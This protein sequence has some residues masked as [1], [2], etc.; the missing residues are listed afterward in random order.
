MVCATMIQ[1]IQPR[2]FDVSFRQAEPDASDLAFLFRRDRV[3]L[4]TVSGR[5]TVPGC[6]DLAARC[7]GRD[8]GLSFLFSIDQVNFF[9]G[10]APEEDLE[11]LTGHDF[12][13]FREFDPP[14][15]GFA[16]ATAGHLANWRDRTR[17]C[18]RCA[19]TMAPSQTERAMVCPACGNTVYPA[20][21]PVVIVGVID[22]EKILM[23]RYAGRAYKRPALIA[24]FAEIGESLESAASREVLEE[25]G[26]KIRNIRYYKSQPWAFSQSVLAGF[27][28]DLDGS[29]N[30]SIDRDE[31]SEAFWVGR[32][33]MLDDEDGS[34]VSLTY[35][36][37]R[38]FRRLGPSGL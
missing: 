37:I 14:W 29:P 38:A 15:L 31:L 10:D 4:Q 1:D 5:P 32:D 7:P 2:Q 24:G 11:G 26:L 36:M 23:T 22:G 19:G 9:L 6:G 33:E 34:N 8:F 28:A 35:D 30:I 12:Q 21:A 3:L 17:Y 27:F 16:G 13:V 20:I 18:G 25:V